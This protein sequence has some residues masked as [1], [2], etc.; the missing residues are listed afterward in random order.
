MAELDATSLGRGEEVNGVEIDEP[1]LLEV[2]RHGMGCLGDPRLQLLYSGEVF[3]PMSARAVSQRQRSR[4][5]PQRH[6]AR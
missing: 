5:D 3:L 4:L 1:H 2:E 6:R